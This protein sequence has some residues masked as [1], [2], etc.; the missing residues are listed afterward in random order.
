L[1]RVGASPEKAILGLRSKLKHNAA[2][3][4]MPIGLESEFKGIVDLIEEHAVYNANED[5]SELRAD[6]IPKELRTEASDL[7]Q[8]LLGIIFN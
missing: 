3:I 4:Q 7:R 6:E 8:Q 2:F 5:G 1:D